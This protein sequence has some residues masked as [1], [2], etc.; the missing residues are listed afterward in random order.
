MVFCKD[1]K[2][3][4]RVCYDVTSS[5]HTYRFFC[6]HEKN[7]YD[8]INFYQKRKVLNDVF[9]A[10]VNKNN[11]CKDFTPSLWCLFRPFLDL[12]DKLF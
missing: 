9:C 3:S 2:Y 8:K 4:K 11:E 7:Y 1:C 5:Y 10:D 12:L 6:V